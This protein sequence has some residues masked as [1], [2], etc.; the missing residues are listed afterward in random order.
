[1]YYDQTLSIS[2]ARPKR[3]LQDH[4][5][6]FV[7]LQVLLDNVI[8]ILVLYGL[9]RAYGEEFSTEYS[10]LSVITL[11]LMWMV[12]QKNGV[13]RCHVGYIKSVFRLARAWTLVLGLLVVIGFITQSMDLFSE[14]IL[15]LWAGVAFCVQVVDFLAS[16]SII[17]AYQKYTISVEGD[18]HVLVIGTS[19]LANHLTNKINNNSWL[20][21]HV[22]GVVEENDHDSNEVWN[23]KDVPLLGKLSDLSWVIN[24]YKIKKVYIALPM[25]HVNDL[26]RI[27]MELLNKNIDVIW[28]PDIFGL[29]LLNLN[30]K[31]IAG[32][33]LIS[34]SESP[35]GGLQALI[36]GAIDRSIAFTALIILSP[37][38]LT[39]AALIKLSSPGPVFFNQ[40]RH[41]W[42]GKV[43]TVWKF[44]SMYLHGDDG[45]KQ[46]I[47]DD[48]RVT[49]IGRFIR[50]TSIDE[51]PQLFNV[52]NG[53]MA[54]VGPRP[55][56]VEHNI[57]FHKKIE[58]YLARH[59]IKPGITG[60][61]QTHGC[62]GETSTIAQMQKRVNYDFAYIN[63]W[64]IW[65]D[66]KI[67]I[68]TAFILFTDDAY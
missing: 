44:R 7:W 42:E 14:E 36:K 19:H 53:S 21:D 40:Q 18:L 63:N 59:R 62:R 60:L 10:L 50:K 34:L 37:F 51:L 6:L 9:V 49:T 41:G 4:I 31:E 24:R 68:K 54:L 55:H 48:P 67:L 11:L 35:L 47:K 2:D 32:V 1:M 39:V 57:F 8:A 5:S 30:V 58:A 3:L 38:L 15:F 22:V 23:V 29:T 25:N 52:L 56:S 13:Y 66:I 26:N 61:A 28:A 33:P 17:K 27:N 43:I 20:R 46:A 12:Y 16:N 45:C 65:L 64:S